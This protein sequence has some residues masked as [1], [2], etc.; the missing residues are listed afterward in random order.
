MK[1]GAVDA[2]SRRLGMCSS[3]ILASLI[4]SLEVEVLEKILLDGNG[5]QK[6]S[7]T[8]HGCIYHAS[9]LLSRELEPQ[10]GILGRILNGEDVARQH[11]G[12]CTSE[13]LPPD[14]IPT[15]ETNNTRK[16]R[17]RDLDE[18]HDDITA[19]HVCAS[20]PSEH[21]LT[22]AIDAFFSSIH[23]WIPFLHP[24]RFGKSIEDP[25]IRPKLEIILHAIVS[26]SLYR[27]DHGEMGIDQADIDRQV[28]VSRD[29]GV[30]NGLDNLMIENVQA[31]III[32]SAAVSAQP[33]SGPWL[34]IYRLS[35]GRW[36]KLGLW[37]AHLLEL[38]STSN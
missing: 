25:E 4:L 24:F 27:V 35:M 23:H 28:K 26:T 8:E 2:L 37:S 10:T 14:I 29:I 32:A 22:A 11:V 7:E 16:R 5:N 36:G 1:S 9:L 13:I 18:A 31:L 21:I 17:R 6:V 15:N 12:D 3:P 38:L 30:L 20:L 34:S 33:M 19:S